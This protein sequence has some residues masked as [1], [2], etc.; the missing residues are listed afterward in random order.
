M[1]SISVSECIFG[2][3]GNYFHQIFWF[4]LIFESHHT[5]KGTC[6]IWG[7]YLESIL[8]YVHVSQKVKQMLEILQT[9][10]PWGHGPCQTIQHKRMDLDLIQMLLLP[11]EDIQTST[12]SL[13]FRT[14]DITQGKSFY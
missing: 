8:K 13:L 1:Y 11:K 10:Q 12:K 3:H 14:L 7:L 2:C 5:M 9:I 4:A 6:E